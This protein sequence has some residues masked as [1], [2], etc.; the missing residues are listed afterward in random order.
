MD[1]YDLLKY[2]KGSSTLSLTHAFEWHRH[3]REGRGKAKDDKRS[4][5]LHTSRT[6]ENI[7]KVFCGFTFGQFSNNS[8]NSTISWDIF[9]YK[10]TNIN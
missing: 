4:G 1:N 3:S 8:A 2:V 7:N 5:R 6:A 10:L 9:D